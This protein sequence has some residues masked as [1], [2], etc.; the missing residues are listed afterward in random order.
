M[1]TET[2]HEPIPDVFISYAHADDDAP[3]GAPFGRVTLFV[4]EVRKKLRSK[5]GGAGARVWMDHQLA[6]NEKV[7]ATLDQ[8]V[9]LSRALVLFM[10]PGYFRSQ[11]CQRELITFLEHHQSRGNKERVFIVELDPTDRE[12]WH[13]R[14]REL[15]QFK[16]WYQGLDSEPQPIGYPV[17]GPD[18]KPYWTTVTN[19]A[20]HLAEV[21]QREP[22]PG[23]TVVGGSGVSQGRVEAGDSAER[24]QGKPVIW[25]A[26]PTDDLIDQW[27]S[28]S[29]AMHQ[30]GYQVLPRSVDTYPRSSEAE[31]LESARADLDQAQV[32]VQLLGPSGG[33]R[34]K[35]SA[36]TVSALQNRLASELARQ[37]QI[38]LLPWRS[39]DLLLENIADG[40]Y[41]EL[42]TGAIACGFEDFRQK[43]LSAAEQAAVIKPPPSPE[44]LAI[45]ISAAKPDAGLSRTISEILVD[46]GADAM[47]VQ[48]EPMAGQPSGE[49]NAQLDEILADSHGLI[50]VY[51]E[52]PPS[53][54][55]RQFT[56]ASKVFSQRRRG[57][58]AALWDGPPAEKP[59]SGVASR[60]L[61][62]LNCRSGM[63]RQKIEQFVEVLRGGGHG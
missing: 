10:S 4:E 28:L 44:T 21:L 43:V 8:T 55:M 15:S 58:W 17:P 20:N 41:R 31:F 16:L 42:L 9:R 22:S 26:D 19:L 32:F 24:S 34:P 29:A 18:E 3:F 46:L 49:F 63:Q 36:L 59:D 33:R 48:T 1:S 14:L 52:A 35:D 61:M 23:E 11:W 30:A 2:A 39:R 62:T 60:N 6:G 54:V 38:L 45:C 37:K 5:L 12:A 47:T 27:E 13:A 7:T 51:G 50:I 40:A 53:W 57:V 56:R 25:I